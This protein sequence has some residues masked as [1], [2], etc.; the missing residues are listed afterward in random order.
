MGGLF[1]SICCRDNL[2]LAFYRA[3]QGKRARPDVIE[4]RRRFEKNLQDIRTNLSEGSYAFGDYK[5]FSVRDTKTR[6]IHAP[7]FRDRV[8][9]HAVINVTGP[10]FEKGAIR[11]SYACR[12]N[13]GQH[14]A[15]RYAARWTRRGGW[16]GKIDVHKFYDSI[17]HHVVAD[18]LR[19]RFREKRLCKLFEKLLAS[20]HSGTIGCGLPIG[21][22]T[23]QY[24]GNFY[25]DHLDR[26]L[27]ASG[28]SD[29]Y[30]RYMDDVVIWGD[31]RKLAETKALAHDI[32]ESLGLRMKH[33][34]EWNRCDRGVPFL[35]FVL[36]P[37]RVRLGRQGRKRL[38][39]KYRETLR[40]YRT[41]A[42]DG[43]GC[44]ERLT[45]LFAHALYADDKAW[46]QTVL[47]FGGAQERQPRASRRLV[48]QHGQEV[49][50][51]V[52][53][54]E[55]ARQPQQEP[56]LPSRLVPWH[57]GR[58]KET[59]TPPDDASSRSPS[60]DADRDETCRKPSACPDIRSGGSEKGHA[61]AGTR[62]GEEDV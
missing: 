40:G 51:G 18:Q 12:K 15:L 56:G 62:H 17:P 28:L 14:A 19:R 36:Y 9:H 5:S 22:L 57:G 8:V 30:L 53:Q 47:Q 54:Q 46:R 20:Y 31:R 24:L 38:R 1:E 37:D 11:H 26:S 13:R 41:G 50:L 58:L 27:L 59:P 52:S 7:A 25:L 10:V 33:G 60:A 2:A 49:P 44:Q 61:G 23:S 45:A 43:L 48:E 42:L 39:R 6:V 29:H 55:E 34:G 4:F 16:Y 32:L 35:G 21:A 3:A